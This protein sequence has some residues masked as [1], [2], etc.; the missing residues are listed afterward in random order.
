MERKSVLKTPAEFNLIS[1]KAS[2]SNSISK[3]LKSPSL[4]AQTDDTDVS[5]EKFEMK[6]PS[7]FTLSFESDTTEEKSIKS[8]RSG[9]QVPV[10]HKL[11]VPFHNKMKF[12]EIDETFYKESIL[13]LQEKL[14]EKDVKI[15]KMNL[16]FLKSEQ[17]YKQKIDSLTKR[18]DETEFQ[19]QMLT[20]EH[21]TKD[22]K[23]FFEVKSVY[24]KYISLQQ[25][26]ELEKAKLSSNIANLKEEVMQAQSENKV[27]NELL[28]QSNF[29]IDILKEELGKI[30]NNYSEIHAN[31]HNKQ[32]HDRKEIENLE[33]KMNELEATNIDLSE[34]IEKLQNK[35]VINAENNAN[36]KS[37]LDEKNLS[38]GSKDDEIASLLQENDSAFQKIELLE[39]RNK[40]LYNELHTEKEHANLMSQNL[41]KLERDV[42]TL[43]R[44]WD[45]SK[46]ELA[47]KTKDLTEFET[48]CQTLQ[49]SNKQLALRLDALNNMFAIQDKELTQNKV[50]Q[51]AKL[52][53][54][55]RQ[56]VYQLLVQL[57]SKEMEE[58]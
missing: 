19:C 8:R 33:I 44:M 1:S 7:D 4:F 48:T 32:D 58:F 34:K 20:T 25:I 6:K 37:E 45:N 42:S 40:D 29:K 56:K 57:K 38:I 54:V 43:N 21:S 36:L 18:L 35:I 30:N 51:S 53:C 14:K 10:K 15:E 24:E 46:Y 11:E 28:G 17:E 47:I 3:D 2:N 49:S 26:F 23:Y 12:A 13:K 22:S 55:W 9:L 52:I 50:N 31:F 27:L 39:K 41:S 16:D 5:N